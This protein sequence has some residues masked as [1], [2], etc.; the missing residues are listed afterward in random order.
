MEPLLLPKTHW[1][2]SEPV[3]FQTSARIHKDEQRI[4]LATRMSFIV[5]RFVDQKFTVKERLLS[6]LT[7]DKCDAL[8]LTDLVLQELVLIQAKY[9]VSVMMVPV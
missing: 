2:L 3:P 9:Q 4:L 6:M 7:S 8:S 1:E 5:I